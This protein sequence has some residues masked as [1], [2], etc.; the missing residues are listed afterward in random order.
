MPPVVPLPGQPAWDEDEARQWEDTI[1]DRLP[2]L[3]WRREEFIRYG[4]RIGLEAEAAVTLAD[5]ERIDLEEFRRLAERGCPAELV[6][7]VV[8]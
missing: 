1:A 6:L 7:R 8:L 3:R 2:L 5:D 4:D